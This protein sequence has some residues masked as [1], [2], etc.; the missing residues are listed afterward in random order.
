MAHLEGFLLTA[1]FSN[2]LLTLS[3]SL[4]ARKLVW[5]TIYL[6]EGKAFFK[7]FNKCI[8][9]LNSTVP[10]QTIYRTSVNF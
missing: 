5:L 7:V 8:H 4:N 6:K 1:R 2:V 10:F 3:S 9:N